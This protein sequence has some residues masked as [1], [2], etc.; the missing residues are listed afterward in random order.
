MEG[1]GDYII[2]RSIDLFSI[3]TSLPISSKNGIKIQARL[4]PLLVPAAFGPHSTLTH[5]K[6]HFQPTLTKPIKTIE[7][8]KFS[9]SPNTFSFFRG[10]PICNSEFGINPS[11]LCVRNEIPEL[12]CHLSGSGLSIDFRLATLLNNMNDLNGKFNF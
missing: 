10:R 12:I 8:M 6:S 11:V 7:A 3:V 4:Y 2:D 1:A 5:L 9:N